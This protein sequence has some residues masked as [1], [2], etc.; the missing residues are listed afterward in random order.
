MGLN[1]RVNH[2]TPTMRRTTLFANYILIILYIVLCGA[3]GCQSKRQAPLPKSEETGMAILR[4]DLQE[5]FQNDVVVIR[6]DGKEVYRKTGVE[7]NLAI[8]LADSVELNVPESTVQV[9]VAVPSRNSSESVTV[10][11]QDPTHLAFSITS[12]GGITHK[13]SREPFRYM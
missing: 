12:G 6:V 1:I 7:T 3:V 2:A 11:V 5:G 4:I 8:A 13:T 9:E 10:A